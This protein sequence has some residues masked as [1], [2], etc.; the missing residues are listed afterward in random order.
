MQQVQ[1]ALGL[2]GLA[3]GVRGAHLLG[4]PALPAGHLPALLVQL[5]LPGFGGRWL[6]DGGRPGFLFLS[7]RVLAEAQVRKLHGPGAP[8]PLRAQG[9][10][11]AHHGGVCGNGRLA[12]GHLGRGGRVA[13]IFSLLPAPSCLLFLL[14]SKRGPWPLK[15]AWHQWASGTLALPISSP[16]PCTWRKARPCL[17][18]A[19]RGPNKALRH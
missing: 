19:P 18:N 4:A 15:L 8:T 13:L 7:T 2:L 14:G 10:A 1:C 16:C 12:L 5:L 11:E 3:L 6:L 9:Q 17:E